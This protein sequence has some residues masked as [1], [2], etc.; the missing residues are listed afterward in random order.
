MCMQFGNKF[1]YQANCIVWC[2]ANGFLG[3]LFVEDSDALKAPA[4]PCSAAMLLPLKFQVSRGRVFL[5]WAMSRIPAAVA[6]RVENDDNEASE[7]VERSLN[8]LTGKQVL[9][10]VAVND[11]SENVTNIILQE[12]Q[13]DH[14]WTF[15]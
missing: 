11:L 7:R 3:G 2:S 15:C 8:D 14:G 5:V 10:T 13:G 12:Q 6:L 1:V 4:G 9:L